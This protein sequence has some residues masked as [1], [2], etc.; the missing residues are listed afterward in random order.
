MFTT[1]KSF[2]SDPTSWLLAS[3]VVYAL[4]VRAS[5]LGLNPFHMD[6]ALYGQ[7]SLRVLNFDFLLTG[8]LNN[9]KPPLLFYLGALTSALWGAGENG[10]RLVNV[11]A[12]T[13]EVGLVF[14]LLKDRAGRL[15]AFLA[16]MLLACSPMAA[17]YGA[18]FFQDS[19]LSFLFLASF[20]FILEKRWWWSG[21][22]WGLACATKQTAFFFLPFLALG[23]WMVAG[24]SLKASAKIWAKGAAFVLVPLFLWSA[25]FAHPRLGM[26]LLMSHN[27]GEVG[28]FHGGLIPQFLAWL[29]MGRTMF[30]SGF[31]FALALF[32][33]ALYAAIRLVL[34][35]RQLK[36]EAVYLACFFG[37]FAV[38][39]FAGLNMRKF[40]RYLVPAAGFACVS[41][42]L[43]ASDLLA[44][45]KH[46]KN[47]VLIGLGLGLALVLIWQARQIPRSCRLGA[48]DSGT[49]GIAEVCGM[50]KNSLVQGR[51]LYSAVSGTRALAGYYLYK[52]PL[53]I[54]EDQD[55][56]ALIKEMRK[57]CESGDY[58]LGRA[59]AAP[60]AALKSG[61]WKTLMTEKN[62]SL[63]TRL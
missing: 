1:D 56:G 51:T 33:G 17:A 30:V 47:A 38:L 9:D 37:L 57:G 50:L 58:Y 60:A 6:E 4:L 12:S 44:L 54:V 35:R 62:W 23:F 7:F 42:G 45:W 28:L 20:Y 13:A 15:P 32:G 43:M 27:Q 21:L 19:L 18:A 63:E 22:C 26:I 55:Y 61:K 16:A 59:G 36:Q 34:R 8:G 39:V 31:L 40:D 14:V 10:L 3:V 29:G 46:P 25:L 5:L 41:L 2:K 49:Q 52:S 53:K 48:L 24:D 11:L